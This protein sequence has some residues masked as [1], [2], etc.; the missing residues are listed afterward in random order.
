MDHCPIIV[1]VP[2]D[3]ERYFKPFQFFNYM[4]GLPDFLDVVHDTWNKPIFGDPMS[5]FCRKLKDVKKELIKLNSRIGHASS[6]VELLRASL[7][8]VQM[9]MARDPL[10][11]SLIAKELESTNL[12]KQALDTKESIF[13]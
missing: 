4:I 8:S 10:D 12:L 13:W 7:H 2:L 9:E 1:S 11:L 6:N 5:I 3:T